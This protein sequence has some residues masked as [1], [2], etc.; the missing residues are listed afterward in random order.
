MF[1]GAAWKQLTLQVGC[2]KYWQRPQMEGGWGRGEGCERTLFKYIEE[3]WY[4]IPKSF[5]KA[6]RLSHSKPASKD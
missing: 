4:P 6:V 3:N 5:R 1:M 2:D